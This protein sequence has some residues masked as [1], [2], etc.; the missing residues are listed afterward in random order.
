MRKEIC[1]ADD[2][3]VSSTALPSTAVLCRA[4]E[5]I[6]R[7]TIDHRACCH[8]WEWLHTPWPDERFT[9]LPDEIEPAAEAAASDVYGWP[10]QRLRTRRPVVAMGARRIYDIWHAQAKV[11]MLVVTGSTLGWVE[12]VPGAIELV[13]RAVLDFCPSAAVELVGRPWQW[14]QRPTALAS[15]HGAWPAARCA[16][17]LSAMGVLAAVGGYG[18]ACGV[19]AAEALK[20]RCNSLRPRPLAL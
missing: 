3:K 13:G 10:E 17:G 18:A 7:F 14:V 15:T 8:R 11:A 16:A 4:D 6:G 9:V 19:Q 12:R 2:S 5:R 20:A 1:C